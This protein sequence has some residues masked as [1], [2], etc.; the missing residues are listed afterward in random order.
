M[1]ISSPV[2]W[3]MVSYYQGYHQ[4]NKTFMQAWKGLSQETTNKCINQF[5]TCIDTVSRRRTFKTFTPNFIDI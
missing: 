2:R 5:R 1:N 3:Y 4:I